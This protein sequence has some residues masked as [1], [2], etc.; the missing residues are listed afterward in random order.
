[1][2]DLDIPLDLELARPE[3]FDPAA[4]EK[5]FRELEFRL[6]MARLTGL[7]K[8]YS[9]S[10]TPKGQQLN[11]FDA[12]APAQPVLETSSQPGDLQP[13]QVEKD[14]NQGVVVNTPQKLQALVERLNSATQISFDTETTSTD[15]MRAQL[16]GIAL[17]VEPDQGYYIP[18][19]HTAGRVTATSAGRSFAGHPSAARKSGYSEGRTQP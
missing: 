1:M 12:P 6:L 7:V 13:A 4:V 16:V 18:V 9:G 19:G 5:V 8:T 17:A 11:L 15:Q 3:V 2:T 10:P 14:V